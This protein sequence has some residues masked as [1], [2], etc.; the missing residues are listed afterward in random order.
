MHI[1]AFI[2]HTGNC[3][4]KQQRPVKCLAVISMKLINC[5]VSCTCFRTQEM[6]AGFSLNLTYSI[7]SKRSDKWYSTLLLCYIPVHCLVSRL[8]LHA[9]VQTS[10]FQLSMSIYWYSSVASQ[11]MICFF[12]LDQKFL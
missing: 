1:F 11:V 8:I 2:W 5:T 4:G 6:V 7:S 3:S 10:S 9:H 12:V